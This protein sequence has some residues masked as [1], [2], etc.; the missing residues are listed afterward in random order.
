MSIFDIVDAQKKR[1]EEQLARGGGRSSAKFW[2]PEDGDNN[3]RIMPQWNANLGGQ[4]W[5]EVA[6][7]WNV[8]ENQRGPILCPKN[9]PDLEGECPI[10]ELV[11]TLRLDKSN[12][13]AQRYMKDIKAKK[14]YLLNIVD[15]KNPVYTAQDVA[16]FTQSRPDEEP[17]FKVGDPKINIYA[18][19][20]TIFDLIL[21]I[22]NT[23]RADITDL[24]TGRNVRLR[25]LP[26]KDRLKTRYEVY[27]D[28]EKSA[29]GFTDP[30]LPALDQVGFQLDYSG[31]VEVLGRGRA[32]EVSEQLFS[33]NGDKHSLPTDTPVSNAGAGTAS[34]LEDQMR[35]R[36]QS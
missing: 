28:F 5:R 10:C 22:I 25:K 24:E 26:N 27:P 16:E 1:T 32:A 4:F 21:G 2:K 7:H 13:E 19:P 20:I 30:A 33:F 6:Q 23:Q 14:T 11:A 18:C 12:V 9:T 35:Q 15:L 31:M 17:T 3:I 8:E 34:D 36:L 29:A